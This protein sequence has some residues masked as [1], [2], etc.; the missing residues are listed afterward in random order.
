MTILSEMT[1]DERIAYWESLGA[2][3][4]ECPTCQRE[5]LPKV[6]A[7]VLLSNI[8]APH[9]AA[10]RGCESGKRPHCTCDVCF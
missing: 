4:V 2:L 9:H 1:V 3:D 8:F 7:G 10:S 5:F 6:K